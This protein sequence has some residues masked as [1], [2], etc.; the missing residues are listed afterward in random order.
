MNYA[1]DLL[2][3]ERFKLQHALNDLDKTNHQKLTRESI[4]SK[5]ESIDK[6]MRLAQS[7]VKA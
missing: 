2:I 1:K 7:N 6:L 3:S 4:E 5:I